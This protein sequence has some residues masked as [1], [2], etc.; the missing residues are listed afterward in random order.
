MKAY[1]RLRKLFLQQL[2]ELK[3]FEF[4]AKD[5]QEGDDAYGITKLQITNVT[6]RLQDSV[7]SLVALEYQKTGEVVNL[8]E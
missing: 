8:N 6:Q 4:S 7:M 5:S 2:M 3:K 1:Q